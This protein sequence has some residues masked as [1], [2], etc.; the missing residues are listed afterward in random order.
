MMRFSPL[1]CI[2]LRKHLL[3]L[4]W[5]LTCTITVFCCLQDETLHSEEDVEMFQ[6]P[7]NQE[8]V[9]DA[10]NSQL[11]DSDAGIHQFPLYLYQLW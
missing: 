11:T 9:V 3:I 8:I 7:L 1:Y 10:S 2:L 4:N 5:G 6:V